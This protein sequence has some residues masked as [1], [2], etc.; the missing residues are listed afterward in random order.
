LKVGGGFPPGWEAQLHGRQGCPPPPRRLAPPGHSDFGIRDKAGSHEPTRN[1]KQS[2]LS[3][4]E[5]EDENEDEDEE[6][7]GPV[8]FGQIS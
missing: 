1:A 5:D 2:A 7:A 8:V 6:D 3:D 4:F